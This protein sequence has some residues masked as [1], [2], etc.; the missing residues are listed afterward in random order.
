MKK[1]GMLLLTLL[2]LP[3]PA[4]STDLPL[5]FIQRSKNANEVHYQL[6]VDDRCRIASDTP[7]SALWHLLEQ[8]PAKTTALSV[9]DQMAYGVEQQRVATT[10]VSFSLKA[11]P[12]KRITA[13]V[14]APSQPETCAAIAQTELQGHGAVLERIYVQTEEG[15]FKP[16]VIYVDVFGKSLDASATPVYERLTP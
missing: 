13:R 15:G 1:R 5:F 10:E 12:Q 6:R 11:L 16:K 3:L 4:W 14:T 9:F 7:V 2:L 8:R